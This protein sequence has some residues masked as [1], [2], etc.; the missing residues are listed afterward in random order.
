VHQLV[1][2]RHLDERELIAIIFIGDLV[3]G[4]FIP[5]GG[6][7]LIAGGEVAHARQIFSDRQANDLD[8]HFA[9]PS[10]CKRQQ[11]LIA[12]MQGCILVLECTV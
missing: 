8:V 4:E 1:P 6:I 10:Q 12:T 7:T 2:Q 9:Y 5:L 11:R 3:N